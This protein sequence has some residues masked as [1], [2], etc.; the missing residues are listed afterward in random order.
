MKKGDEVIWSITPNQ[1]FTI[2]EIYSDKALV[3]SEE[4]IVKAG[5]ALLDQLEEYVRNKEKKRA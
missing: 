2:K 5:V 4:G 1:T 3:T